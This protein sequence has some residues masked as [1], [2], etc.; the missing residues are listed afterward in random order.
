MFIRCTSTYFLHNF[1]DK[2]ALFYFLFNFDF[3]FHDI[4]TMF[5]AQVL[6]YLIAQLF[7]GTDYC[8]LFKI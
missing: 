5:Y 4:F 1:K 2:M 3:P 8:N 6:I 7:C